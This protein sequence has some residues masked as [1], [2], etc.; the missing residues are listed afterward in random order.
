LVC[1]RSTDRRIIIRSSKTNNP[2]S[3]ELGIL[4]NKYR[5]RRYEDVLKIV[6]IKL[7][8]HPQSADLFNLAGMANTALKRDKE[9]IRN[10]KKV[11]ENNPSHAGAYYNLGIVYRRNDRLQEALASYEKAITLKPDYVQAHNNLGVLLKNKGD[12]DNA[13]RCFSKAIELKPD[14]Q[15]AHYNLAL[16][17]KDIGD[18]QRALKSFSRSLYFNPNCILSK[19][20][21]ADIKIQERE[22]VVATKILNEILSQDKKNF[23]AMLSLSKIFRLQ[24][25][26][27]ET[28]RVFA[29]FKCRDKDRY[30]FQ[31]QYGQVLLLFADFREGWKRY[32]ARWKIEPM[33]KVVWPVKDREVWRGETKKRILIFKEQGIGDEVIFL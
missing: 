8:V 3:E 9:A 7:K 6:D 30:K 15:N 28:L 29:D 31:F 4:L 27:K 23:E 16:I 25:R 20:G 21:I 17:Y 22:L 2:S 5:E 14:H 1:S 12:Y 11:I 10:Y 18:Y 26:Y 24:K 32:E 13:I 33:N 19:L